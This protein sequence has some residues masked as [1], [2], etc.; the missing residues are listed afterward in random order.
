MRNQ[1]TVTITDV[2]GSR[3]FTLSHLIRRFLLVF[4]ASILLIVV[5]GVAI[6]WK[7]LA[8]R[9]ILESQITDLYQQKE[10]VELDYREA[11]AEQN[12]LYTELNATHHA[13]ETEVQAK[14]GQLS[15]LNKTFSRLE[16]QI[17]A[18][19]SGEEKRLARLSKD[20]I[21]LMM[22]RIPSGTPT[23]YK[24]ISDSYGWRTHPITKKRTFHDGM[25]FSCPQ[26]S[27]VQTTASGVV[28]KAEWGSGYGLQVVVNHGY[29][30]K[31]LYAHLSKA[32]VSRGDVVHK[33]DEI[34]L[35]GN[36]GASTGAHLHYEVQFMG[37]KLNPKPFVDWSLHRQDGIFKQVKEV[38]WVSFADLIAQEKLLVLKQSLPADA[39]LTDK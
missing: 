6:M 17:G 19:T 31:T 4:I 10:T 11:L 24:M 12:K 27:K 35:S 21:E 2:H 22:Q 23:N 1:L 9:S 20:E 32:L 29:G 33:G 30:F 13:L 14:E 28:E 15:F 25:D 26:G 38:P 3:Q 34:A 8:E 18:I 5:I 39:R 16:A 37:N 7:V 36:T